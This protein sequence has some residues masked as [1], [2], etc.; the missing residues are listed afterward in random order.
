M[1]PIV[2]GLLINSTNRLGDLALMMWELKVYSTT[3][4]IKSFTEIFCAHHRTFD[5]P[6]WESIAPWRR[7]SHD[8]RRGCFFPKS[9]IHLVLFFILTIQLAATF[10]QI[11]DYT[12]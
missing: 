9:K 4:N 3:M 10:H 1:D 5:M 7:P 12:F 11:F 2:H 6:S 8:V